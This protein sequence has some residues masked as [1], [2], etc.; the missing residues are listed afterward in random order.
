[1]WFNYNPGWPVDDFPRRVCFR[2]RF[3]NVKGL[4]VS[5]K[6]IYEENRRTRRTVPADTRFYLL[7]EVERLMFTAVAPRFTSRKTPVRWTTSDQGPG[8]RG[9]PNR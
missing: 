4:S 8:V 1:M 6:I 5:D 9:N 7:T 3:G 2:E